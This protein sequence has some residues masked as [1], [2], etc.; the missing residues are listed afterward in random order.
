MNPQSKFDA[1]DALLMP[2][3]DPN[4]TLLNENNHYIMYD[5]A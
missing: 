5:E 4:L 1:I 3:Y 2:L